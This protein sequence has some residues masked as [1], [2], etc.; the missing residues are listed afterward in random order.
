MELVPNFRHL[1]GARCCVIFVLIL[2]CCGNTGNKSSSNTIATMP[3]ESEAT[4][5]PSPVSTT[6]TLG[7]EFGRP[8]FDPMSVTFVTA[9]KGWAWGPG[10]KAAMGGVG[11]GVLAGTNDYGRTWVPVPTPGINF[12]AIGSDNPFSYANGVRFVNER[13][14]FFLAPHF[15]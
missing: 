12:S 1:R 10:P 11:S 3:H 7:A 8:A 5:T 14:D 15:M 2:A 6:S 13:W 4:I 9:S